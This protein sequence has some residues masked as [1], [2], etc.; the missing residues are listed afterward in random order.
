MKFSILSKSGQIQ[1]GCCGKNVQRKP[2]D[3]SAKNHMLT[4]AHKKK[5]KKK[6]NVNLVQDEISLFFFFCFWFDSYI[7]YSYI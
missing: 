7:F 3:A 1:E 6:N 2:K 4:V 5:E